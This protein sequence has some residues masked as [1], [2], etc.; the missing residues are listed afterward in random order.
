MDVN[1]D[2]Y[3]I[4]GVLPA[5]EVIV[6]RAAYRALSQKYHPDRNPNSAAEATARMAEINEAYAVLS[7]ENARIE[8]DRARVAAQKDSTFDDAESDSSPS[9]DEF[10]K[11]WAFAVEYFPHLSKLSNSLGI[12]SKRLEFTFRAL[13]L[14]NKAFDKAEALAADLESAFLKRYFGNNSEIRDVAKDLILMRERLAS[15]EL[16]K[17]VT[18]L[19]TSVAADNILKQ[20]GRKFP[21]A[22]RNV[23]LRRK[24]SDAI[25]HFDEYGWPNR[26]IADSDGRFDEE[27][28]VK[29]KLGFIGGTKVWRVKILDFNQ[30][31]DE[32]YAANPWCEAV[33][34]PAL[35]KKYY[36]S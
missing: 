32:P 13:L 20:M 8:Y 29:P 4:L 11:N 9:S 15:R 28:S 5:A 22:I 3:A 31:F 30:V 16:N 19:G 27:Y 10:E 6:I 36:L 2:Y 1:K 7:D 21:D 25:K 26:L 14:E 24:V 18:I 23:Y 33:L 35:R 17:A 12:I 34:I